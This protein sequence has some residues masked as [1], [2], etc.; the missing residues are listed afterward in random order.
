MHQITICEWVAIGACVIAAATDLKTTKI[1]NWLT[2]PAAILGLILNA[3]FSGLDGALK[4]VEGWALATFIMCLPKPAKKM[5]F[6]DVK[7]MGAVGALLGPIQF[8]LCFFYFSLLYGLV[9]CVL[10]LMA[11]PRSQVKTLLTG[12]MS[13][14]DL[15]SSFDLSDFQKARARKIPLGPMI[16]GGVVMG[17]MLDKATMHF[18]GFNWY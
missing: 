16:L 12:L 1:Y 8:L 2:F 18:M 5:H 7:M 14:I 11:I 4:S 6:G 17:I 9:A 3:V 15:S 10:L 13:G